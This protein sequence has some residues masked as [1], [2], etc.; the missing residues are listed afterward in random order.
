MTS[1]R[2][3][4]RFGANRG[5]DTFEGYRMRSLKQPAGMVWHSFAAVAGD[6]DLCGERVWRVAE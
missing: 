1:D 4:G 5:K 3:T 6:D 2:S